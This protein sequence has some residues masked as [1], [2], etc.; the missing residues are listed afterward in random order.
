MIQPATDSY[1]REVRAAKPPV[2]RKS[3]PFA[4]IWLGIGLLLIAILILT[5]S[6]CAQP[7]YVRAEALQGPL[8]RLVDRHDG[9]VT[10]DSSISTDRKA[11]HLRDGELLL[12]A[13]D[14]AVAAG[15]E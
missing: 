6:S 7:G 3:D 8:R 1:H 5:M 15:Q 12:R 2:R 13:V 14:E 11:T 4:R 9:Y 10:I